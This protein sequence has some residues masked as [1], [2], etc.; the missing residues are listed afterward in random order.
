MWRGRES[1]PGSGPQRSPSRQ[2]QWRAERALCPLQWRGRT[3]ITPVSVVPVR[4][5]IVRQVYREEA[6]PA[7]A[8]AR[9]ALSCFRCAS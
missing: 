7:S 6:L 8:A 5:S 4:E 9:R 1:S 3:G 2:S